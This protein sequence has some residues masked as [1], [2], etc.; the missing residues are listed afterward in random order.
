MPAGM[1]QQVFSAGV[2]LYF[3]S[4]CG[5]C[6]MS[7][8][9]RWLVLR[10]YLV[11]DCVENIRVPTTGGRPGLIRLVGITDVW[12]VIVVYTNTYHTRDIQYAKFHKDVY[13]WVLCSSHYGT[14][15]T[16]YTP[17][18]HI[19]PRPCPTPHNRQ[20]MPMSLYA[21]CV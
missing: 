13:V 9:I 4:V 17:H 14:C 20:P 7:H 11:V 10:V 2:V 3:S 5:F 8:G 19:T 6:C 12:F 1:I 16:C 18:T 21:S 15:F